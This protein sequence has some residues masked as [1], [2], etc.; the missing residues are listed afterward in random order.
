MREP[1]VYGV[2][3]KKLNRS[4]LTCKI[5][6]S[7]ARS[8]GTFPA[9]SQLNTVFPKVLDLGLYFYIYMYIN[10]FSLTKVCRR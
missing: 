6:S 7:V 9:W 1:G 10:D 4:N 8:M 2:A 3:G 5:A